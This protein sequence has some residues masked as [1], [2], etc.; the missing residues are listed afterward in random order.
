ML[1]HFVVW[2]LNATCLRFRSEIGRGTTLVDS[3]R[4]PGPYVPS[5]DDVEYNLVLEESE[6]ST[7]DS[8]D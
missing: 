4:Y 2:Y 6:D 8:S 3:K 1:A 7:S 5:E